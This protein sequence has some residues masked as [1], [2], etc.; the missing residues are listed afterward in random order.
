MS[1][2]NRVVLGVVFIG[3]GLFFNKPVP[4]QTP[5]TPTGVEQ[6]ATG[7]AILTDVQLCYLEGGYSNMVSG[8]HSGTL[9]LHCEG[10][11]PGAV[12]RVGPTQVPRPIPSSS[13]SSADRPET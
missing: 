6:N 10:L 11:T 5:L 9:T 4:A 3:F 12:Y 2:T 1:S 13:G 7:Y 8:V